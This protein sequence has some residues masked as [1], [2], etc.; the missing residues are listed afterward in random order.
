GTFICRL[1]VCL[2]QAAIDGSSL[3]PCADAKLVTRELHAL[4]HGM[5]RNAEIAGYFLGR[6]VLDQQIQ[7]F[8]L[9][10]SEFVQQVPAV[11]I[12]V[13]H[14]CPL[15]EQLTLPVPSPSRTLN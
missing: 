7:H 6:L 15:P 4:I 10:S 8:S 13:T 9:L 12:F 2:D 3:A 11:E 5:R 14:R 1:F